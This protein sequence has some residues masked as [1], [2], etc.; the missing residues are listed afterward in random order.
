[1][2]KIAELSGL[3]LAGGRATRMQER[4]KG[5]VFFDQKPLVQ[6]LIDRFSP[7][8][9][10]ISISCNRNF[11]QYQQFGCP[12]IKD[13]QSDFAG[14][15]AGITAGLAACM[16]PYLMVMPCDMPLL[17][18]HLIEKLWQP[19]AD[20]TN[21]NQPDNEEKNMITVAHDGE[22][23]QVLVMILPLSC[24]SSIQRYLA[25]GE[26]SVHGWLKNQAVRE[27]VFLSE[28]S[29]FININ[30][31]IELDDREGMHDCKV[32]LPPSA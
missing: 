29:N 17:P 13:Q 6:H 2:P 27:V 14:P 12:L 7:K 4:D 22:R 20:Q 16:T 1:M 15:L 31:Q 3:I 26:C 11:E 19:I 24:R 28:E 8:L 10:S 23:L 32:C 21:T 18:D 5:L 25:D 30:S 9:E